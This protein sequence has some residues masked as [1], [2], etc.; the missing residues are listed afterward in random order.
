MSAMSCRPRSTSI[1]PTCGAS[2]P[3][4]AVPIPFT[5]YVASGTAWMPTMLSHLRL[6]LTMLY[7]LAALALIGLVGGGAYRVIEDYFNTTTNL[8]LQHK[9]AHEFLERQ[10]QLPDQLQSAET[11]WSA[12][13]SPPVS[14]SSRAVG[15]NAAGDPQL[16]TESAEM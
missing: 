14:S 16:N 5:R 10:L 8:A 3:F 4:A 7:M 13:Q 11:A 1:S 12:R 15:V 2:S 9:M 6:R